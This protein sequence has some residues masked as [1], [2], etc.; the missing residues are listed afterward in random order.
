MN[1][2][3]E[4]RAFL[5]GAFDRVWTDTAVAIGCNVSHV[6]PAF[7]Q[8]PQRPQD[9]IVLDRRR[10]DVV[11]RSQQSV[12]RQVQTVGGVEGKNDSLRA[13][14]S[15]Q[16]GDALAA[17]LDF[18]VNLHCRASR[19]APFGRSEVPLCVVHGLVDRCRL[20]KA[21][22]GVIEVNAVQSQP[23]IEYM[24]RSGWMKRAVLISCPSFLAA[25]DSR[26][27]CAIVCHRI[28]R[29]EEWPGCRSLPG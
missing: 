26:T 7:G 10:D 11:S 17:A 21:G 22:R 28:L 1:Q 25:I 8:V 20:G 6:D 19:A 9:R 13:L 4:T 12:K 23:P 5:E 18:A 27:A 24:G 16:P 29:R 15:E 2:R 14:G 3:D